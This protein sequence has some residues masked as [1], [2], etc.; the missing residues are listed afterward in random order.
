MK[1]V[2]LLVQV[3]WVHSERHLM[4]RVVRILATTESVVHGSIPPPLPPNPNRQTLL[5]PRSWTSVSNF[6]LPVNAI[7]ERNMRRRKKR[8]KSFSASGVCSLP[9]VKFHLSLLRWPT[10][11][12]SSVCAA[13]FANNPKR[14]Y[15]PT[16]G[17]LR[18]KPEAQVVSDSRTSTHWLT[19]RMWLGTFLLLLLTSSF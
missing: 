8:G 9:S 16:P 2:N 6:R 17:Y 1:A 3:P 15:K 10:N 11:T 5:T 13:S 12:C 4:M 7:Q 14:R 18:R 19:L